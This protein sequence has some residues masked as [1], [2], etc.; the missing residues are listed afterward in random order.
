MK[1]DLPNIQAYR[2][3]AKWRYYYRVKGRGKI[4]LHGTPGSPDFI[5]AYEAAKAAMTVAPPV[6]VGLARSPDGTIAGLIAG[7]YRHNSF[8]FALAPSTQAMRRRILE[9][10]RTEF[11]HLPV[12]G[13]ERKHIAVLLGRMKPFAARN[14]L[15]TIKGLFEYA[16]EIEAIKADPS[17]GIK[18]AKAP[19]SSGFHSWSDAEI[20]QYE[21]HHPLGSRPRLLF[22]LALYTAQRRGDLRLMGPGLLREGGSHLLVKPAKTSRTTA[23]ELMIPLHPGLAEVLAATP[24]E[25]LTWITTPQGGPYTSSGLGNFFRECCNSAGLPHCSLHGLRKAQCRLLA[26]AGCSEHQIAAITGHESLALIRHYTRAAAQ[27]KLAEAA[28]QAVNRTGPERKGVSPSPKKVSP[29]G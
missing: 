11:G 19:T 21:A 23:K 8:A 20:A 22:A 15:K 7:Y 28:F 10:F 13:V 5:A 24:L 3:A 16:V 4:R 6:P 29:L 27:K 2:R 1:L 17:D 26:E 9:R 14:W 25:H 18:P 12:D